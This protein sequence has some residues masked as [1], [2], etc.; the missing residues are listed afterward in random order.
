MGGIRE[1]L[2][3]V[4]NLKMMEP[5]SMVKKFWGEGFYMW[6]LKHGM[7]SN[8]KDVEPKILEDSCWW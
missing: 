3:L 6:L 5:S 4:E 7:P 8:D 1:R 2:I